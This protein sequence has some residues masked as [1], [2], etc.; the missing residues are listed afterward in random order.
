[1]DVPINAGE[2]TPQQTS[3]N[4]GSRSTSARCHC[5]PTS[6]GDRSF[7]DVERGMRSTRISQTIDGIA[8]NR[9]HAAAARSGEEIRIGGGDFAD[10]ARSQP[11]DRIDYDTIVPRMFTDEEDLFRK[12][13][14]TVKYILIV[15]HVIILLLTDFLLWTLQRCLLLRVLC[16]SKS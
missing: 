11:I 15:Q 13:P 12:L 8:M 14:K 16:S 2:G 1:M 3:Q 7:D 5:L 4:R 10:C 9:T 6:K